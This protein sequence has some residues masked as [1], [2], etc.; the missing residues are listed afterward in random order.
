MFIN[1]SILYMHLVKH[2]FST[3]CIVCVWYDLCT[4]KKEK[5]RKKKKDEKKSG[6]TRSAVG[7]CEETRKKE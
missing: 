5:K 2:M 3:Y 1:I 4:K 6:G 7:E